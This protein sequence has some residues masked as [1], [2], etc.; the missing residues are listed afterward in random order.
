MS[1]CADIAQTSRRHRI[2]YGGRTIIRC[3]DFSKRHL[4]F[5]LKPK[6][7]CFAFDVKHR[8]WVRKLAEQLK[9]RVVGGKANVTDIEEIGTNYHKAERMKTRSLVEPATVSTGA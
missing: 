4:W 7:I 1:S 3:A 9:R 6:L 8:K 2:G 5:A